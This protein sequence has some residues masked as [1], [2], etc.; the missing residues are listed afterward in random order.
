[1]TGGNQGTERSSEA[2]SEAPGVSAAAGRTVFLSYASPDAAVV[3]Q[4][5]EFL[6]SHGVACWMAPRDVKPGAAYADAIVRAINEASALV[7]V[8]SASATASEHV[9]REVERAASK[10]KQVVAFRIDAANLSAELEYFLSRSQWIDVPS[11]GMAGALARLV[12]AVGEGAAA[13]QFS[14]GFGGGG[15]ASRAS[16]NQAVGTASVAKRMVV[17][18]AI[19]DKSIAVLPF[20]DM[21]EKHDQE[22]FSDGL[23]EELA[24][25]LGKIPGMRVIGTA[26][27]FQFKQPDSDTR[28]IAHRLGASYLVQG[29]VRRSGDHIRVTAKLLDGRSGE[30]KWSDSYDREVSDVFKVQ[31]DIAAGLARALQITVDTELSVKRS[32]K[33]PEAHDLYLKGITALDKGTH[34]AVIESVADFEQALSLDPEYAPA[35][36]SLAEAYMSAGSEAWILPDDA[37]PKARQWAE[38]ALRLDPKLGEPHADLAWIHVA[39]DW[40][41]AAAQ[42]ELALAQKLGDMVDSIEPAAA[43]AMNAGHCDQAAHFFKPALVT[44]PLNPEW[45]NGLGY[46]VYLRCGRYA[47][48]EL[49]ERRALEIRPGASS[50]QYFLSVALMLQGKFDEALAAAAAQSAESGQCEGKAL[51]YFAMGRK[52]ESDAML[53][54]CTARAGGYWA[55][56]IARIHAFRGELDQAMEWL[57]RAYAQHDE[58]L[59]F[60]KDDPLLKKLEGDPRYKAFLKKMNLPE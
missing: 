13:A 1:V 58:D 34:S 38:L 24:G 49:A 48:A 47:D 46:L 53:K 2:V 3:N 8:L 16:I 55:S 44:D 5:C 22:Y 37:Y 60:I 36:V 41:W 32:L 43:L 33:S 59:Y 40:D 45:Y 50:D 12:E 9:S 15:A 10:K 57:E 52:A 42:S 26:S 35:A 27:S 19:S 6:E 54:K 31:E 28:S 39:Y 4:V 56:E 30:Q 14:Q 7:L 20:V 21:S 17:A 18:A 11:L 23:A 25:L 51:V 29:G